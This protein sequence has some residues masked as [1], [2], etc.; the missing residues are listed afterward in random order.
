MVISRSCLLGA[1]TRGSC[2]R[3]RAQLPLCGLCDPRGA[4]LGFLWHGLLVTDGLHLEPV[5]ALTARPR[6]C[7]I[8]RRLPIGRGSQYATSGR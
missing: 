2:A 3:T 7:M 4:I 6:D 8:G 5:P 1:W